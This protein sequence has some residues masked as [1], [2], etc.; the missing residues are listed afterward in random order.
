MDPELLAQILAAQ[1]PQ[2]SPQLLAATGGGLGRT[3]LQA[4]LGNTALG[5]GVGVVDPMMLEQA[6]LQQ[7]GGLLQ[8]T[9]SERDRLA[10][11][12]A[13]EERGIRARYI[14]V[15]PPEINLDTVT[16]LW[17]DEIAAN[18]VLQDAFVQ[19]ERGASVDDAIAA[20]GVYDIYGGDP[21]QWARL[22]SAFNQYSQ[23]KRIRDA[24]A[25][26][27]NRDLAE[28]EARAQAEIAALPAVG[29]VADPDAA[30]FRR[31]FYSDTGLPLL[32]LLPS[33]AEQY[34]VPTET[35]LQSR[36]QQRPSQMTLAEEM[37][38][39]SV[40][41]PTPSAPTGP[42]LTRGARPQ[43]PSVNAADVLVNAPRP[44]RA[45]VP[46]TGPSSRSPA[47]Q[48]ALAPNRMTR[49]QLIQEAVRREREAA[50]LEAQAI[51]TGLARAGRTPYQDAMRQLLQ[52]GAL[53]ASA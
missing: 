12:R 37:L 17:S 26:R 46:F 40:R 3:D 8:Q 31:E 44:Q 2:L 16:P 33:V 43:T 47:L 48:A 49:E 23:E 25:L 14:T 41:R 30:A 19:L 27:Y 53:E 51:G 15:E 9:Q 18:P 50:A 6:M 10:R 13:A 24:A 21:S 45:G 29:E 1:Q 11:E 38:T 28:N 4:L 5:L 34:Q 32:G 52:Y 42:V 35:V 36:R 7:Y 39:E 22:E 20:S